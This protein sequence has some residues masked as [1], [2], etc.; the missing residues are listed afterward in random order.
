[1]SRVAIE[2][3]FLDNQEVQETLP[4]YAIAVPEDPMQLHNDPLIS[5]HF[6]H[7]VI[8]PLVKE[9]LFKGKQNTIVSANCFHH[10]EKVILFGLGRKEAIDEVVIR[11]AAS[12]VYRECMLLHSKSVVVNFAFLAD[13][14]VY[15]KAFAEGVLLAAHY[16]ERFKSQKKDTTIPSLRKVVLLDVLDNAENN[17]AIQLAEKITKGVYL[18]KELVNAPANH[19]TPTVLAKTA[20]ELAEKYHFD[21]NIL[22][23]EDCA[24]LGMA[25]YLS[26]SQGSDQPPKFIHLVYKPKSLDPHAPYKKIAF[27]GKGVTFDSGGLNLKIGAA[28]IELMKCDMAGAAALLGAAEAIGA[29][30][31]NKEI[32]FIIAATE[33]MISGSATKPGDVVTASNGTTIEIDNT[34]AEGR[35]T[36]A[37]A[38]VYAERLEVEVIVDLATLTG[39]IVVALG[40]HIAGL[41]ANQ[42]ELIQSLTLAA[43]R[44]DEK[45]W[46]MPLEEAYREDMQ[47]MVADIRNTGSKQRNAGSITAALFLKQFVQKTPW[48]HLDIAGTAWREQACAYH[49]AGATGFG[50]RLLVDWILHA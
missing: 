46:E 26:V 41:F 29:L 19:V 3:Q 38:L 10:I 14:P 6:Y 4:C 17:E 1:M 25:A 15:I 50:V 2:F 27:I 33:N 18:A 39:A 12:K 45:V 48:A 5:E 47:S 36:L 22:E 30:K 40:D 11:K 20:I 7:Q 43:K 44:T 34:D 49:G 8:T 24:R 28:H 23:K 32:H 42:S 35:L 31:P 16:D 21:I 13:N 9:T 37:D